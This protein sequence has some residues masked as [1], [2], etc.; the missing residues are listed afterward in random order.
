[1]SASDTDGGLDTRRKRLR[2]RAWHRGTKE[3]DLL[4]G[5]FADARI[6]GLDEAELDQ[7]EALM[8]LPD[9]DVYRWIVRLDPVPAEFRSP[10][11]AEIIAFHERPLTART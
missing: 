7:F 4:L 5:P 8:H 9:P 2:F 1:M 10:L 3:L 11:L 6:A